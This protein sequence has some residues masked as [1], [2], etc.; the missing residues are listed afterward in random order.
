VVAIL[1]VGNKPTDYTSKDI[2]IISYLAD[3]AWEF[4]ERKRAEEERA[5]LEQQLMQV[6]KLESVG[7]LAGGVAHDINN[8]MSVVIGYSEMA[9]MRLDASDPVYHNIKESLEAA[10]KSSAM[11]RQLLAFARKQTLEIKPLDLNTVI[12]E[13][14]KM[15]RRTLRENI[16]VETRLSPSLSMIDGDIGQIEQV[17]MNLAV[18]AQD[19]MS[20]GGE[21]MIETADIH[22]KNVRSGLHEGIVPGHYV[23]LS[24]HDTGCGIDKKTMDKIFDPFFTTKEAG[25]G[26]GLGLSTAY[27][28]IMQHGGNIK[29]HSE[30]GKGTSV[31]V[32]FPRRTE[33]VMKP[34]PQKTM[35]FQT[36]LRGTETVLLVEDSDVVREI[37]REIL[38][39]WGYTVLEADNGKSA[40]EIFLS[41]QDSI[42]LLITDVIMPDINGKALYDKLKALNPNLKVLYIS[43]YTADIIDRHGVLDAGV[44]FIQKP[45]S[46]QGFT[47]KVREA[48]DGE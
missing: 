19:A 35:V 41:F 32:Y 48:L 39:D 46:I 25:K 43:G 21:L 42:E 24:V 36:R 23:L 15:L 10:K 14:L 7:R 12:T 29:V 33:T 20:D 16:H 4:I 22:L 34:E 38:K 9:L 45:F 40:L 1:G 44:K 37:S 13:F 28:I 6:Q 17:I 8:M 47:A 26:T 18:N 31:V 2:E 3:V 27:G 30:P 5:R 11:V